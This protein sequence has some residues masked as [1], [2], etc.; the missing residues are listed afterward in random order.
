MNAVDTNVLIYARDPRDSVKQQK[1]GPV[2]DQRQRVLWVLTFHFLKLDAWATRKRIPAIVSQRER[3]NR[4]TSSS[5]A[6]PVQC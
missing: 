1:S 5:G 2:D 3:G 6:G 4:K